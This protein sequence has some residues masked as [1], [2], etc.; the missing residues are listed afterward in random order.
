MRSYSVL[1]DFQDLYL[2]FTSSI[3]NLLR[4]NKDQLCPSYLNVGGY[5]YIARDIYSIMTEIVIGDLD[6]SIVEIS[7]KPLYDHLSTEEVIF[8]DI[9]EHLAAS[10]VKVDINTTQ[11]LDHPPLSYNIASECMHL[12]TQLK[13]QLIVKL[14]DS[15]TGVTDLSI[16]NVMVNQTQASRI[17]LKVT[18][19]GSQ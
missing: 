13:H 15:L 12:H 3:V 10:Y 18:I 7:S 9:I 8:I 1:L 4:H 5:E 6:F 14:K 11:P 17:L 19:N 2:E 16:D